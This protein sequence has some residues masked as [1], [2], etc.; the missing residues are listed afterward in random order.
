MRR[1]VWS[2]IG[3]VGY[4]AL[5]MSPGSGLRLLP[6]PLL[7]WAEHPTVP[8]GERRGW[9]AVKKHRR[10][11]PRVVGGRHSEVKKEDRV[12]PGPDDMSGVGYPPSVARSSPEA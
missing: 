11:R 4:S 6:P 7:R 3:T 2:A 9:L 5:L 10:V 12:Q 8:I 1:C